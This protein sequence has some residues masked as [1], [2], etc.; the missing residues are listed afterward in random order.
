MEVKVERP[1]FFIVGGLILLLIF[2]PHSESL[3]YNFENGDQGWEQ[4][5]GTMNAEKGVLVVSGSDGVAVLPDADWKQSWTEYTVEAKCSM[6]QGP[7]NMGI[8]VRYQDNSTYYIFAIMNG[9]Q[10]AE[11]W[12][13]DQGNY[14]DD[15]DFQ[16]ANDLQTWYTIR[17]V[18]AD[19]K[20][21]FYV[22]D[23]L[24]TEWEDDRLKDG[25]VGVRTYD[26]TSNFDDIRIFG[27]GI[28]TSPGEPGAAVG[29][30][31]KLASTW[32]TVKSQ[33]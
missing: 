28:P 12:T 17:I 16:F 5:N 2:T 11:V 31:N 24:I 4:I 10:Q 8:L 7:D 6:E 22:D 1:F 32:G 20:F 25:K 15:G 13:R 33:Y 27:P 29:P 30:G 19:E 23:E 26:S 18:V 9:R 21:E 3:F 14:T